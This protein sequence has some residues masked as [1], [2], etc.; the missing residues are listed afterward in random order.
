MYLLQIQ[1]VFDMLWTYCVDVVVVVVVVVVI[2]SDVILYVYCYNILTNTC[3]YIVF[4]S[5]HKTSTLNICLISYIYPTVCFS[6][7]VISIQSVLVIPMPYI[8]VFFIAN[9]M[10]ISLLVTNF[11]ILKNILTNFCIVCVCV[12]VRAFLTRTTQQPSSPDTTSVLRRSSIGTFMRP[13][14]SESSNQS[15]TSKPAK[16]AQPKLDYRSMV[17][18]DDMPELFVSFDSKYTIFCI[19]GIFAWHVVSL[20]YNFFKQTNI[21][22]MISHIKLSVNFKI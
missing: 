6:I 22:V 3:I 8:C 16:A 15:S 7:L 21:L 5:A 19:C 4:T 9:F 17:S 10:W 11:L 12:C 20:C 1:F 13:N 2:L 18:I 14:S